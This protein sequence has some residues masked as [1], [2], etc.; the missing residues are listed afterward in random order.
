M[1]NKNLKIKLQSGYE[2]VV[3]KFSLIWLITGNKSKL[4]SDRVLIFKHNNKNVSNKQLV[5]L[6]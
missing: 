2:M 1:S 6:N 3:N 5:F 4:S